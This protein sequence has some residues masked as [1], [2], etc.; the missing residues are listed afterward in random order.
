MDIT[1]AVTL[2][3]GVRMPRLG[4][5]VW[6]AKPGAEVGNAV[7]W[8]LEAGYRHIDTAR[9]YGNEHDVG[10]ALRESGL[11]RAD[12]FITTKLWNR[13]QGYAQ[14]GKAL[15]ASLRDLGLDYVDLYLLHWPVPGKRLESWRAVEEALAA[16]KAR[17][18]GVSNFQERHLDELLAHA[19]VVTAVDQVEL[20]PFLYQ[21][22]LLAK[23]DGLGIQLE[24][25]SPLTRGR[26]LDD[27]ALVGVA[28]RHGVSTAQVLI[29]WALQHDL[30]VIPKSVTRERIVQNAD[31]FGFTLDGTDMA[32][33]DG[34]NEDRRY[35]WDPSGEA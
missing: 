3:N 10:A 14:A 33:L 18:I 9:V 5:G 29:R 12:V 35:A 32:A 11:P 24:A 1:S 7:R 19:S 2:N 25:Y 26:R 22:E 16:G 21:R 27:P 13:D 17:A 8:A 20:T 31:V 30:V 23:C 34:L 28:G 15:D 4:L 6:Q